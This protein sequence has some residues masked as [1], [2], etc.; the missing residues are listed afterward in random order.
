MQPVVVTGRHRPHEVMFLLYSAVL[1]LMLVF[2][3][4][5]PGSIEALMPGWL[6]WSWYVLL[7]GSGVVGVAGLVVRDIYTSLTL[8]RAAMWGQAAAFTIY[9][10][11]IFGFGGWRGL[12]A[13]ALCVS[14]AAASGWR[15]RQIGRE[16]TLVRQAVQGEQ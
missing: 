1:G 12:A 5:P 16:M 3:A 11:G 4:K 15:L 10:L 8:E 9:A 6:R 13:G 2:G 14:L 7:L